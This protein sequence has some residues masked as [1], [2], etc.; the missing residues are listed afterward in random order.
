MREILE[1]AIRLRHGFLKQDDVKAL[2]MDSK[3]RLQQCLIRFHGCRLVCPAQDVE[4]I[5][6]SLEKNGDYCRDVSIPASDPIYAE[7]GMKH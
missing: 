3:Y 6:I 4:H 5:I 2:S 7:L 1:N